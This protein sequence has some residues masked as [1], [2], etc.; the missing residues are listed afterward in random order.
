MC[1]NPKSLPHFHQCFRRHG[2]FFSMSDEL[3]KPSILDIDALLQP[4]EGD[5]PS[6]ESLRYSGIYDEIS[7]ARRADDGLSQGAWKTETK[8]A[9]FARVI[10]IAVSALTERAKDLQIAAWLTEALT[11]QHGFAGL[12]DG[13]KL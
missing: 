11:A 1:A 6:G 8:V 2:V 12:R 9:D 3:G 10:D 13:L 4:I 7:E 5:N